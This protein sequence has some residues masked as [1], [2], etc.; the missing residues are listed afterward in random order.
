MNRILRHTQY[1][2]RERS[3]ALERR[4]AVTPRRFVVSGLAVGTA[5]FCFLVHVSHSYAPVRAA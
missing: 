3:K 4:A 1:A 2:L 5:R